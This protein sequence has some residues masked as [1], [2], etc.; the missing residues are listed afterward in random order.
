MLANNVKQNT[1]NPC[2]L[3]ANFEPFFCRPKLLSY[4]L[5]GCITNISIEK[6][7]EKGFLR[8]IQHKTIL[9]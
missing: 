5:G 2:I 8:L 7:R 9:S 4:L 1:F 3:Q 6:S